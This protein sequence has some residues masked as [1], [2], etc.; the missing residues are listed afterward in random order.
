MLV[1]LG[2]ADI[3]EMVECREFMSVKERCNVV[4]S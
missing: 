1:K 3:T 4:G 2:Q